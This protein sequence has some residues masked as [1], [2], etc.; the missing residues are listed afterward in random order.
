MSRALSLPLMFVS[1]LAACGG[2]STLGETPTVSGTFA[3]WTKGQSAT[4]SAL[5]DAKVVASTTV[6]TN[7]S[8]SLTLPS[9]AAIASQLTTFSAAVTG[10]GCSG[11][12]TVTPAEAKVGVLRFALTGGVT[13]SALLATLI[14]GNNGSVTLVAGSYVYGDRDLSV[15][16]QQTCGSNSTVK[17][18]LSATKGW[19]TVLQQTTLD[20]V[21]KTTTV[22]I[23]S[24]A[25][26]GDLQWQTGL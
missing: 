5:I 22:E 20:T 13:A 3:T 6:D 25:L 1:L 18:N 21:A 11:P 7:G 23:T 19:N 14:N 26:S 12:L 24:A 4:L 10:Q 17:A 16:G 2:S 15:S 8:F 9:G